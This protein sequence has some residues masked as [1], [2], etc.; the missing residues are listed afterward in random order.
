MIFP[1]VTYSSESWTVKKPELQRIDTFK[2]WCWRRLLKVSGAARRSNQS[3][4]KEINPEYWLEGLML[5]L[6]YSG[7]LMWRANS[8]EKSLM[9]GKIEG[10]RRRGHQRMRWLDGITNAMDM[11]LGKLQ[12]MV[13]TE[14][15]GAMQSTESQRVGHDWAT[16]QQQHMHNH[17]AYSVVWVFVSLEIQGLAF[18]STESAAGEWQWWEAQKAH[19]LRYLLQLCTDHSNRGRSGLGNFWRV[20]ISA[21]FSCF[22]FCSNFSG[23]GH[24]PFGMTALLSFGPDINRQ[25]STNS[26]GSLFCYWENSL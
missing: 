23:P 20:K 9:L 13:R 11:N 19:V 24:L 22:P 8:L 26:R 14:K 16:E 12:E 15:P 1:V 4:L 21:S 18:F 2:L 10:R 5:K 17:S 6:Q 3:I 25:A 7:P